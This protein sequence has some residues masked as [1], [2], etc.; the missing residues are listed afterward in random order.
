MNNTTKDVFN[1]IAN[2]ASLTDKMEETDYII[3]DSPLRTALKTTRV[4]RKGMLVRLD[5]WGLVDV[6]DICAPTHVI[7]SLRNN[8][9]NTA[10]ELD[11]EVIGGDETITIKL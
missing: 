10:F 3:L 11:C 7:L 4:L 6:S 9:H 2:L 5:I 1:A 8:I